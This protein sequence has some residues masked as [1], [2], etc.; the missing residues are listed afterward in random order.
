MDASLRRCAWLVV[1][2][3]LFFANVASATAASLP[4]ASVN[5]LTSFDS[6][7]ETYLDWFALNTTSTVGT[8][9]TVLVGTSYLTAIKIRRD[10]Q[11]N[12]QEAIVTAALLSG[13][14][15]IV[16]LNDAHK[17]SG[18]GAWICESIQIVP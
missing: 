3:P 7:D 9:A 17:E 4:A 6:T 5:Q 8:C 12:R 13:K 10:A 15:V 11:G 1:L 2:T 18:T 14:S 16:G